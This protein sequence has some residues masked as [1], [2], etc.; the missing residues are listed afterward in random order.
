MRR[1]GIWQKEM[2]QR[3]AK[4]FIVNCFRGWTLKKEKRDLYRPGK[5]RNGAGEKK[6]KSW[7]E[8]RQST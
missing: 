5:Q 1:L 8:A 6:N 2:W 3:R 4:R 7:W